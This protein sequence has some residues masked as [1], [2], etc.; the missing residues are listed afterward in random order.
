MSAGNKFD[1]NSINNLKP[2]DSEQKVSATLGGQ[3][4]SRTSNDDGT[5][6]LMWKYVHGNMF[7]AQGVATKIRFSKEG[8]MLKIV[9][10]G[11]NK[12]GF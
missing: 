11:T 7:G 12:A 5:Y 1:Y 9:Q 3:P 10:Q 6:D 2:G 8:K 4:C